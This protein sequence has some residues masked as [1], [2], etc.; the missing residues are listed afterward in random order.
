MATSYLR[1]AG[2]MA[3]AQGGAFHYEIVIDAT[4]ANKNGAGTTVAAD[5]VFGI[6]IPK[7]T[8]IGNCVVRTD[9]LWTGTLDI[10]VA[11]TNIAATN[12]ASAIDPSETV[13]DFVTAMAT[14]N[15]TTASIAALTGDNYLTVQANS[16]NT[17][18]K[19]TVFID[20]WCAKYA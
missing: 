13:G 10:G 19:V 11:S 1:K 20:G 9:K 6:L 3:N 18:G 2:F 14:I 12:I 7:G 5:D 15:A 17:T 16:A 4:D 8:Q